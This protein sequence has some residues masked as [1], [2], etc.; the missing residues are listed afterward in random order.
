MLRSW[1]DHLRIYL[2]PEQVILVRERG[3]FKRQISAKQTFNVDIQGEH[4]W[5]GALA[6]LE[7][8][9]KKSEWQ[10]AQTSMTLSDHFMRY[11]I[12]PWDA[13]LTSEEQEALLRHRFEEVYGD[14]LRTWQLVMAGAGYGKQGLVCAVDAR[15]TAG[16]QAAFSHSKARLVSV[17]PLLMKAFNRWRREIGD[18]GAWIVLAEKSRLTIAL[19]QH[20]E[21]RGI[22]SK[23]HGQEW[24]ET[25]SLLL[26]REALHLG[27]NVAEFP[28]YLWRPDKPTFKPG[29]LREQQVQVLRLP[30]RS[31]LTPDVD[32]EFALALC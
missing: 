28:V 7:T 14:E 2:H 6:T 4:H 9:L 3:L 31:G 23:S 11:R 29:L 18:R 32:K 26:E 10:H 15:L 13:Q 17:K 25:L 20:G 22:R 16:L 21:W 27:V 1:I 8:I 24:E 12:I 19:V 5:S 30:V